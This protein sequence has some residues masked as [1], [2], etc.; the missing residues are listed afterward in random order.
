MARA[1][2]W[3]RTGRKAGNDHW[4][5]LEELS[6]VEISL[7]DDQWRQQG[8]GLI[9]LERKAVEDESEGQTWKGWF[10]AIED[11]YYEWWVGHHYPGKVL[12]FHFCGRQ[13][14]RCTVPT[15]YRDPIHVDVFRVLPK[16]AYLELTWLD[17]AKKDRAR[18]ILAE[19]EKAPPGTAVPAPVRPGTGV[20]VPGGDA[21][22]GEVQEGLEGIQGL[23]QALG[24]GR[25]PGEAGE[26]L[27]EKR[28]KKRKK[29]ASDN[30]DK[31]GDA[32]GLHDVLRKRK[33]AAPVSSALKMARTD[34]KK[35]KKKKKTSKKKRGRKN[36]EKSSQDKGSSASS[37]SSS[38]SESLFRLAALPQ[39]VDRPHRLHQERP[40]ALANLTLKRFQELLNRSNGG[41]AASQEQEMPPVARAY[42]NQLYLIRHGEGA[43]G[44]RNVRELRTLSAIVDLVASN[45][46]LRALDIAIQR[47]KPIEVFV[48][49]GQW[50]QASLLEL[51]LPESE[52]R[53]WF[54]QELK[55][56]HQEHKAELRLQKDQWP[57]RRSPWYPGSPGAAAAEQKEQS[58]KEDTPPGNGGGPAPG[59]GK[60]GRGK[61]KKGGKRW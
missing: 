13:A 36:E 53:A 46:P 30:E 27:A 56:A 3:R 58:G 43:I 49:Q 60:K 1:E 45:D 59:K 29:K 8:R 26:G 48:E 40:G 33:A 4:L 41:G 42:L 25:P 57:K 31:D 23:A 10:L 47:M 20:A 52:Q 54:R 44:I 38:T 17:E 21:A 19:H 50:S 2:P 22:P 28:E 6:I 14:H 55:A 9:Q 12:P 7:Y 32:G 24:K 18:G 15:F 34:Q 11:G 5:G 37:E 16:E 39:G 35:A 61:G 51:V